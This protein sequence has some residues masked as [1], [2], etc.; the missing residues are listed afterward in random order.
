MRLSELSR[1]SNVSPATIKFYL[2]EGLLLPGKP[3]GSPRLADYDQ[4][5]LHR[6]RLIRTLTEVGGLPLGAVRSIL[7]AIEDPGLGMH[8]V[9]GAAHSTL[10]INAKSAAP[11][12]EAHA[13]RSEIDEYLA[14]LGWH[15]PAVQA[16]ARDAL[17]AALV[18]LRELGWRCDA[19]AFT[20]Y[21]QLAD[22]LAERELDSIPTD[23]P[24][25][26]TVEAVI[27]GTVVFE[28]A[29]V[30]LRRLAQAHHSARRFSGLS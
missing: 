4:S 9:L 24:R 6:L 17:A 10:V 28:T 5:H 1:A 19:A 3:T 12:T 2:R 27:V 29:L 23:A 20:P 15:V 18:A 7:A 11:S 30:A 25:D 21:A 16:P 26:Q 8:D 13:A 22:R 14:G